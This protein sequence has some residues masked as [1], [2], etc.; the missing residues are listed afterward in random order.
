MITITL[1]IQIFKRNSL[2]LKAYKAIDLGD[3]T[4]LNKFARVSRGEEHLSVSTGS[5]CLGIAMLEAAYVSLC[6]HTLPSGER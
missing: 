3:N 1:T 2:P 4:Y 5:Q 6:N